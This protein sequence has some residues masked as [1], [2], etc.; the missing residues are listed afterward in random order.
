[1]TINFDIILYTSFDILAR[2]E[3]D[4]TSATPLLGT[5]VTSAIFH[6]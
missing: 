2:I 6:P 4:I 1:M 5:T 3:K